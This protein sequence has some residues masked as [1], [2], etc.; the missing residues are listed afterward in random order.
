MNKEDGVAIGSD[1]VGKDENGISNMSAAL[2][3]SPTQQPRDAGR[4]QETPQHE[5]ENLGAIH[6]E[7]L[8]E[9]STI[10]HQP[11]TINHRPSTLNPES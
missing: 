9:P 10:N 6:P 8:P 5:I 3:D 1:S 7:R 11:S 2:P 4:D